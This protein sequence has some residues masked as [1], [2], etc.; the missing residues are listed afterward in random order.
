MEEIGFKKDETPYL[1]FACTKCNQF[2]YVKTVQKTKKCLRCGRTHKV[3]D[4]LNSGEEA[5]G[6]TEAVNAVKRKQNEIAN[7]EFRS[8][9]DFVVATNAPLKPKNKVKALKKNEDQEIDY[10]S[11]FTEV[12]L[13]LSRLYKK[14]P[15]YLI[16][17]K[18]EDY[19]IPENELNKL[20]NSAIKNGILI[21]NSGDNT[22]SLT[23]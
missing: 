2:S 3:K 17:I 18:A 22:Y 11:N 16:E 8:G 1:I 20:I 10:S 7:P 14:F 13:D 21:K 12:I 4:I 6:M 9:S 5:I 23:H 15:K 19:Q